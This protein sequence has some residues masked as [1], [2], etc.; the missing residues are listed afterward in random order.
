[1]PNVNSSCR[2]F[3]VL[4]GEVDLAPASQL[5]REINARQAVHPHRHPFP[6][7]IDEAVKAGYHQGRSGVIPFGKRSR[8]LC[9]PRGIAAFR[10][11][12][13]R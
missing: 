4:R 5:I 1:M 6:A 3:G 8:L 2:T 10:K 7:Q 13:A 9:W 11:M 12:P